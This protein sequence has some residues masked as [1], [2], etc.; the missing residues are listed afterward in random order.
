VALAPLPIIP[1]YSASKAAA[2]NLTQSLRAMMASEG[3]TVHAVVLGPIVR[4]WWAEEINGSTDR[5]GAEFTFEQKDIHRR[6]QK[7]AELI[8]GEKVVWHVLESRLGFVE[9]KTEWT[10]TDIVFEISRK[11][12]RT[13]L[14][15]THVGLVPAFECYGGC[16]GAW[17]LLYQRQ[18]A[19]SDRNG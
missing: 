1:A 15:F 8:P 7:I 18:S 12:D 19:P 4:G 17:G 3:V 5:L 9:D 10:G 2:F 16:S 13:E 6:T 11:G 14:R